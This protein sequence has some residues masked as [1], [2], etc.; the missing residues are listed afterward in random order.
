MK[1]LLTLPFLEAAW[2]TCAWKGHFSCF[3]NKLCL[4][5]SAISRG[6]RPWYDRQGPRTQ[7]PWRKAGQHLTGDWG[8][9][10][11]SCTLLLLHFLPQGCPH[12]LRGAASSWVGLDDTVWYFVS[13]QIEQ[14]KIGI[15]FSAPFPSTCS[16][17]F[18]QDECPWEENEVSSWKC[19]SALPVMAESLFL[20]SSYMVPPVVAVTTAESL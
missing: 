2:S 19:L 4:L 16:S 1:R 13:K 18:L 17:T 9:G 10:A 7:S 15:P 6:C 5:L 20:T 3:Q 12:S 14:K 8:W 11:S